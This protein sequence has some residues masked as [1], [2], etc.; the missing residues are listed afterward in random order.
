MNNNCPSRDW[1]STLNHLL[2][3]LSTEDKYWCV[4]GIPGPLLE[5]RS[6]TL[7]KGLTF[8]NRISNF[9]PLIAKVTGL[10]IKE[11]RKYAEKIR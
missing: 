4:A 5:M 2:D 1:R 10:D 3:R 6:G 8:G 11:L 7:P 9:I